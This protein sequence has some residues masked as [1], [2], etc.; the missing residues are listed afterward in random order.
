MVLTPN[1]I[2]QYFQNSVL[3]K[4]SAVK[5]LMSLIEDSDDEKNRVKSVEYLEKIGVFNENIYKL[6][7][8]L[9][10]SDSSPKVRQVAIQLMKKSFLDKALKP[11]KWAI[12]HEM[13]Y[14]CVVSVINSLSEMKNEGSK[15]IL[16]SEIKRIKRKK[17]L[18][19]NKRINN[20]KFKSSLKKLFQTRKIDTFN[21][22]ELSEILI[23]FKTIS[24]L[25]NKFFNVYFELEHALVVELNVS[26]GLEVR[27]TPWE[28]MN[29]IK[30]LSE[31]T[32]LTNLKRLKYLDLSNN[33][34][35]DIKDLL[36]LP[37]LTH[38]YV[39]NNKIE[40]L[41]SLEDIKNMAKKNLKF[42]DI[43]GNKIF[44]KI[45]LNTFDGIKVRFKENYYSS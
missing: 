12:L 30:D 14:D 13:D 33:H 20:K 24:M 26:N 17:F 37:N 19:K 38:L 25:I 21:H 4:E 22:D 35:S 42:I 16:I 29:N 23:N 2:L 9:L 32:G 41:E 45:N 5:L 28:F 36:K 15:A 7:E 39:V 27:G 40:N 18:E 43:R 34:V 3:S 8:N 44:D 1:K 10:I 31:I 11:L 6:I